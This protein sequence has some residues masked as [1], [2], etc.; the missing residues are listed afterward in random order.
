MRT[1]TLLAA[2]AATAALAL[3][4]AAQAHVTLNPKSIPADSY[5]VLSVR[6][7][8]EDD[9]AATTK[10]QLQFPAGFASASYEAQAGWK[11]K[12]V[13]RRLARPLQTA[14]GPVDR[15]VASITWTGTRRGL[16]R[17]APGQFRDFRISVKVPGRAGDTLTFG[18]LQTYSNGTVVR[19]TGRPDADK[20]AP[21]VRLTAAERAH[22]A[23]TRPQAQTAHAGIASRTPAPGTTARNVKRVAITFSQRLVTGK[24]D[25][26]RGS[27]RVAPARSGP[28]GA[29]VTASFARQLAAG[30]YT[31]RWRAVVSDGHVQTGSW[32]FRVK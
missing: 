30:G 32:S 13:T 4:S 12:L 23:S 7:P 26:Y 14:Y 11:A 19:W 16:G 8:N 28:A 29:S 21:T 10:V 1:R 9:K 20:P 27:T 24:L 15:E 18:A 2:S 22:G 5:Q 3:P 17:I 31:A 6:V 25:V